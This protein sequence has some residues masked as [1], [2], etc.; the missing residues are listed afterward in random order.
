MIITIAQYRRFIFNKLRDFARYHRMPFSNHLIRR[1]DSYHLEV[2]S[3]TWAV[4][5]GRYKLSW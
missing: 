3:K 4:R 1:I 5:E 2:N